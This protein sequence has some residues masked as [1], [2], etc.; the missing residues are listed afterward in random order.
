MKV[1]NREERSAR[2]RSEKH[3]RKQ[4]IKNVLTS[5]SDDLSSGGGKFLHTRIQYLT[6][7]QQSS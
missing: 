7:N 5:H 6:T 2:K 1:A 4:R 3:S